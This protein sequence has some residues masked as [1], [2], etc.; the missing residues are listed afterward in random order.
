ARELVRLEVALALREA[1]E[2]LV[3]DAVAAGL[4]AGGGLLLGLALLVGVPMLL[5]LW[6]PNH[7][8]ADAVW[9][10]VY[11]V[12]GVGAAVVGRVRLRIGAPPRTVASLRETR[13]W[14]LR[15]ISSNDR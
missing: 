7:V 6:Q 11:V 3:R 1:R 12:L 13:E 2:L 10:G 9:I 4:L 5:V 8:L 15:Q 14:A